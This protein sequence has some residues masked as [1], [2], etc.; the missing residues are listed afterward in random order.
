MVLYVQMGVVLIDELLLFNGV[1]TTHHRRAA[2]FCH[3]FVIV[4]WH[5]SAQQRLLNS[6]T[7]QLPY[8][9]EITP[10][11]KK[12]KFVSLKRKNRELG[13]GGGGGVKIRIG[14]HHFR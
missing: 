14:M 10:P 6:K 11:P 8:L 1:P 9:S 12:G 3:H 13:G 5:Q 7:H 2:V 4:H